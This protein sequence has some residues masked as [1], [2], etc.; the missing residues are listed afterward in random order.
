MSEYIKI[1]LK[2]CWF[3]VI[4]YWF[5]SGL[6]VKKLKN[7]ESFF[8]RFVQ[9]WLP[10]IIAII[11]LGPGEWFGDSLLRENFVPHSDLV[12]NIGLVF[13]VIGAF[14][15][16]WSRYL[17]GKN[18]SLSVQRKEN[19]EL[20]QNGIYKLL[21]H[22]IYTGLLLLFIGNMIIVGDYRGIIA[23]LLVFISFWFK[24]LKEEKLLI[25]TFGNQYTEY[26]NGTKALF[27]FL[28]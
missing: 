16:C 13:C 23:V 26:K 2:L 17:L 25:E 12:G 8:K 6:S 4:T 22:P 1:G 10:L 3:I 5:I 20:I 19:H 11:L 15:A 24:L 9:Y 7:Q 27:P 28:L 14:I 21:R 18:W